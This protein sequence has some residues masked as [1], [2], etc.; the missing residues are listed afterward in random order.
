MFYKSIIILALLFTTSCKSQTLD[1]NKR[2]ESMKIHAPEFTT[3]LEWLN[4][5]KPIKLKDLRGKIVLIDFWTY[6]CINCMHIIPD[7][8]KL[9]E[10][11]NKELVVIGVH[12]AKF[13]TEK[14]TNN[15]RQ[16][17]LR[18]GI[19]HP[20]VND[21]DFA[22]WQSYAANSWPTLIL[23]D[24]DGNIAGTHS[25][26]GIYDLFDYNI[27]QLITKFEGKI[28][29]T[30]IELSL[31][32]DKKEKSLLNFPGKISSDPIN[33]RLIITDSNNNRLLIVDLEGN[34]IDII[35]SGEQGQKDGN[36][37]EAQFFN[38]QGTA[39]KDN[40]LYIADTENHTIRKADLTNKTVT[41]IAGIGKQVYNR[42]PKGNA[43][44]TGLNSPWDLTIVNNILY[45]AMAGPHQIWKIDLTNNI[46]SLHAGNGYENIVDSDLLSSQLAQPSGITNNGNILYFADSEVSAVR[47]ADIKSDGSVNTLIGSGLFNYGDKD[48]SYKKALL[49]HPL[50]IAYS[51]NKLYVA[52]T[53]NNKIKIIDLN[54]EQIN[55]L[56]GTGDG[57][58]LDG[59]LEDAT[60]NEPGGITF[61]NGKLYI[62]DTN[63]DLIRIIDL[64]SKKVST[65]IIKGVDKFI[66][67]EKL[68]LK[69]AEIKTIDNVNLNSLNNIH[70]SL[71]MDNKV[72]INP[73]VDSYI[74]I[75]D[76]NGNYISSYPVKSLD[77]NI[78]VSLTGI[79]SNIYISVVVYYCD[80]ENEGLC[81]IKDLTY[82]VNNTSTGDKFINI[83]LDE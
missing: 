18:Y 80:Y 3:G 40:F 45:I 51:N 15:I 70:F 12:S 77:E 36:F 13:T 73:Y 49:Q 16:A 28:N 9:E 47:S 71:S 32:K 34:V 17:I 24:P 5:D 56:A 2:D 78:P 50:G 60:F 25:G 19:T 22:I 57:G 68:N 4:V 29:T 69:N 72:K 8:K 63:N 35:G 82:E 66:P 23:I 39:I 58:Y 26:E 14:G 41:T 64:S 37:T 67:K 75:Y 59:D 31:E 30:P 21:K 20:V 7:L 65:L 44:D 74:N 81:Y 79:T 10:K 48:G 43:K 11:Y 53:Y 55:T 27:S 52:D 61:L 54:K 38:P 6:C 42:Y 46:I 83:K 62:A 33:N 1:N 76:N